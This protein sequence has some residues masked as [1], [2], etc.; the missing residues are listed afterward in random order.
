V[1]VC[2][3]FSAAERPPRPDDISQAEALALLDRT[4][5]IGLVHTVSNVIHGLGYVCNCCGCCCGTSSLEG[6]TSSLEGGILRGITDFGIE[7]SVARAHYFAVI[8]PDECLG[9]GTCA[10]RPL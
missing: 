6:G 7:S 10:E 1:K 8:D 5:E 3:S 4:E 2:L 9:C